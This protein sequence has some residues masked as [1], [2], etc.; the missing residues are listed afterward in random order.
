M[1][2]QNLPHFGPKIS[3][4][5]PN[6]THGKILL[7]N[8]CLPPTDISNCIVIRCT[9]PTHAI[10]DSSSMWTPTLYPQIMPKIDSFLAGATNSFQPATRLFAPALSLLLVCLLP[11]GRG[12]KSQ[13]GTTVDIS[14]IKKTCIHSY[15]I[16][17]WTLLQK[18]N[19]NNIPNKSQ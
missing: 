1:A 2:L 9:C 18:S 6:Y 15:K 4:T 7:Y 17:Q 3:I 14:T 8:G 16:Q 12:I 13:N 19:S 11:Y 5:V 10:S